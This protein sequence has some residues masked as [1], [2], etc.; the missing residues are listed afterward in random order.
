MAP[1][2]RGMDALDD[3]VGGSDDSSD[4]EEPVQAPA[5]KKQAGAAKLRVEDL[6]RA[7]YQAGPS[8][9]HVPENKAAQPESTWEW[10]RGDRTAE[11]QASPTA[12]VRQQGAH[13]ASYCDGAASQ[14]TIIIYQFPAAVSAQTICAR[15]AFAEVSTHTLIAFV[16]ESPRTP[17][18]AGTA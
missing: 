1:K 17:S 3:L 15:H 11:A 16:C 13:T 12:E 4:D 9:M 6:E 10:S 18:T 8:V 5:P 2:K 7:G 14:T